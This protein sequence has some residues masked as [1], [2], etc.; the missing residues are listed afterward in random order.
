MSL[1]TTL[2]GLLK[3]VRLVL[4]WILMLVWP[5]S[6]VISQASSVDELK[7]EITSALDNDIFLSDSLLQ[8]ILQKC[9]ESKEQNCAS[10][11]LERLAVKVKSRLI[12]LAYRHSVDSAKIELIRS[13]DLFERLNFKN[14]FLE[15]KKGMI[16]ARDGDFY[17]AID[18]YQ[19][20]ISKLDE[21]KDAHKIASTQ[22]EIATCY[23]R[24]GFQD[25]TSIYIFKALPVFEDKGDLK[26]QAESK[27]VLGIVSTTLGQFD[28]AEKYL[29]ESYSK[30]LKLKDTTGLALADISLA[31]NKFASGDTLGC[32]PHYKSATIQLVEAGKKHGAYICQF[33]IANAFYQTA[34]YDSAKY[35]INEAAKYSVGSGLKAKYMIAYKEGTID[36]ELGNHAEGVDRLRSAFDIALDLKSYTDA[37]DMAHYLIRG[38]EALDNTKQALEF[39]KTYAELKDSVLSI[40]SSTV[41]NELK[42]KYE[43]EK[44]ELKIENL[45]LITSKQKQRL[46]GGAVALGLISLLSFFLYRMYQ[47]VNSQKQVIEKALSEKDILLREIHHRVKN[48]L[49]L[50]SSLLTMQGR[51]IDDETA[52]KA[53]NEGKTRV[54]SMAL[55]HQDLYN[56]DN[57]TDIGVKDYVEKLTK[58]LFSTYKVDQQ[59]VTLDLNVDD[60]DIDIDTLVPLG[61][62]I[63]ELITN[64]LKY[65]WPD[66]KKGKMSV[67]LQDQSGVL[68]LSVK[69]D[70]IGYDPRNVR[71]QSFGATLVTAL[72]SQL[73]G[74]M[75]TSTQ[76]GTEVILQIPT[77]GKG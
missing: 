17:A 38:Y 53:I 73:E 57:L 42:T 13:K 18:N 50:V 30:F 24:I 39:S 25:S 44:K 33:N 67:T 3:R 9:S 43:T 4:L 48:N 63:N 28:E 51:S 61:L 20:Y 16:S 32:I 72:T 35:Y 5:T 64:S 40:E 68:R 70:G 52:Q 23:Q 12:D 11:T 47:K 46:Y 14:P 76:Q 77:H 49:Q 71:D 74:E 60:I 55:I 21:V 7:K 56:K 31:N 22:Y 27:R 75:S 19:K 62:I 66:D 34:K 36:I 41:V 65:A 59:Q 15:E 8:V 10:D 29:L 69:D 45:E 1:E 2:I 26:K 6:S 54:R 58:E 37:R